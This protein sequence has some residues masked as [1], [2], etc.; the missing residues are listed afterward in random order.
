MTVFPNVPQVPGVPPLPRNPFASPITVALLVADT[1]HTL[2]VLFGVSWGVF[3]DGVP[4]LTPDTVATFSYRQGWTVS[5][6]PLEQGAFESYDKVETPYEAQVRM[7]TGGSVVDR[8]AFLQQVEFIAGSL[9]LYEIVTPERT[10]LSANVQRYDYN[11]TAHQGLGLL[12]VDIWFTEVRVTATQAFTNTKSPTAEAS[13]SG[14]QVT[15][16]APT[17]TQQGAAASV[18]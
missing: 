11:R 12:V 5:N 13:Q 1:I 10:Y 4:V 9:D 17:S 14:G 15:P 16:T 6:Y 7:A 8:Q 18:Q 3:Q 2:G